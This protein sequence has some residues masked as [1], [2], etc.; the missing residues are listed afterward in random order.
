MNR[1]SQKD[2]EQRVAHL[3][4][5]TDHAEETYSLDDN[6]RYQPNAG[7]YHID[8]AYGGCKLVQMSSQEGC[9]GITEPVS[10]GYCTKRECYQAVNAFIAGI[11]VQQRA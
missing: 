5:I 1:I 9:T 3:N 7:V 2:L 8:M 10:M 6:G 4:N 11:S